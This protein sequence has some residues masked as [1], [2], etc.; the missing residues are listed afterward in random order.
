MGQAT[1]FGPAM[2]KLDAQEQVF[3]LCF[4]ENGGNQSKAYADA[5]YVFPTEG[6]RR[7][8][9]H[10]L[11]HK[12]EIM[13]AIKEESQRRTVWMAAKVQSAMEAL[14]DNPQHPDH[15]KALKLMRDDAGI[16]RA[17]ERVLNVKVEVSDADKIEAIKLFAIAHNL[18]PKRLLGFNPEEPA[19]EAEFS[20]V[21]HEAEE[22]ELG[23]ID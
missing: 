14:V 5:G 11:V 16:S 21:D 1:K 8:G 18:D 22:R 20:E 2:S 15:F 17:V 9:A 6:A 3:V 13:E 23:I 7:R 4:F 19:V 12:K 10:Y